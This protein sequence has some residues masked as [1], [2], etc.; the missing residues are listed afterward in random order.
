MHAAVGS[1]QPYRRFFG[2]PVYFHSMHNAV[3][4]RSGN[5]DQ[6]VPGSDQG[7]RAY[8]RADMSALA[9]DDG[10]ARLHRVRHAILQLL[11][12]GNCT[13]GA[14]AERLGVH[15][16]TLHRHLGIAGLDFMTLLDSMRLE[17]AQRYLRAG[18][19]GMAEISTQLG[20]NAASSFSRWFTGKV[21]ASPCRWQAE[22]RAP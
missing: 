18:A 13:S 12:H 4:V 11:P 6:P 7:F 10:Q 9:A 21:G 19:L 14:V 8:T 3:V 15:R 5:L 1:L 20:F 17:L 22:R 2:C 16:R